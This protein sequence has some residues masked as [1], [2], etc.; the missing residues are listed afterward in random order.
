MISGLYGVT[1]DC[2][3]TPLLVQQVTAALAGGTRV[4]QYRSKAADSQQRL[5]QADAL[6]RLCHRHGALLIVNDHAD[7]AAK[8]GADGVHIGADDGDVAAARDRIGRRGLIG[9]SCYNRL[10][11]ARDAVAAGADY[12]AFGSFFASR[13]KP[14]AVH[15]PLALLGAAKAELRVPIVAIGGITPANAQSL[16]DAGADALAVISAL[17]AASDITGA[18]R[19]FCTLFTTVDHAG[20]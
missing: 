19:Q 13:V 4:I 10:E 3:D 17:F 6:T 11:L 1:P 2:D 8:V 5:Q 7:V 9:V 18:A 14:G 15:A 20:A 12:V 16:I